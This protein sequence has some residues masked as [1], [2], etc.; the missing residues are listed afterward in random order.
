V[1]GARE[2]TDGSKKLRNDKTGL[3]DKRSTSS[4]WLES[5][6][7]QPG[8]T[9]ILVPDSYVCAAHRECPK[10][11]QQAT[12][13]ERDRREDEGQRVWMC[14]T[15]SWPPSKPNFMEPEAV[16]WRRKQY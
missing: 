7:L 8:N 2:T 14:E 15:G 16:C 10:E 13:R 11:R 5:A 1:T 9:S 6:M 4:F 12:K 3:N